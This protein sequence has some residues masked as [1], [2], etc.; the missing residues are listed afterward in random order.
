M[1]SSHILVAS[2]FLRTCSQQPTPVARGTTGGY[3]P[4]KDGQRPAA[5]KTQAHGNQDSTNMPTG[6]RSLWSSQNSPI[7]CQ[8]GEVKKEKNQTP[9]KQFPSFPPEYEVIFW[10]DSRWTT[11]LRLES[12]GVRFGTPKVMRL[13]GFEGIKRCKCSTL[14]PIENPTL[15]R[16]LYLKKKWLVI[17]P[18]GHVSFL[19]GI[20]LRLRHSLKGSHPKRELV[21]QNF[22]QPIFGHY[23]K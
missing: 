10:E 17:F 3:L 16:W 21:Y 23:V 1:I 7:E 18:A 8:S 5:L 13:H 22:Q 4:Q 14:E 12:C 19:E 9:P 11:L 6:R 15:W 2:R 20:L